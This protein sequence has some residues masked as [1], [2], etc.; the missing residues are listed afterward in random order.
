MKERIINIFKH[1]LA[2]LF[3]IFLAML[4]VAA[5]QEQSALREKQKGRAQTVN[6]T[7]RN[8]DHCIST[9]LIMGWGYAL[10][11]GACNGK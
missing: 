6:K 4:F 5:A 11:T 9:V 10:V 3:A 2:G 8:D 7:I 1:I